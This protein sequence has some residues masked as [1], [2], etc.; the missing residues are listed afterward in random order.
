MIHKYIIYNNIYHIIYIYYIIIHIVFPYRLLQ[1]TDY[2][3]L[4]HVLLFFWG[5]S[6]MIVDEVSC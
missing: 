4:S 6:N 2:S 1:N 3:S 5:F